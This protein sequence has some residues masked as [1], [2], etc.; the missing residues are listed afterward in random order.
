MTQDNVE[1]CEHCNRLVARDAVN[2]DRQGKHKCPICR[3][4]L[5]RA[6][7]EEQTSV[8]LSD[9]RPKAP[10]HFKFLVFATV[11]YLI[12]RTIWIIQRATHHG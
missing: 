8:D 2:I 6:S 10:W 9:E 1:W 11:V 7:Q 3:N 4:E 5:R 12:Y